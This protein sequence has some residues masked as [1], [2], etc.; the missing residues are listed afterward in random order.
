[1]TSFLYNL[2]GFLLCPSPP[3][4]LSSRCSPRPL[5]A[6]LTSSS[7]TSSFRRALSSTRANYS[8]SPVVPPGEQVQ[9]HNG[10]WYNA[11]GSPQNQQLEKSLQLDPYDF[12]AVQD[13]QEDDLLEKQEVSKMSVYGPLFQ[14]MRTLFA[15]SGVE[16]W[17]QPFFPFHAHVC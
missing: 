9:S 6:T 2:F 17:L 16:A 15:C 3:G 12:S 4:D 11:P 7:S 1:M 10:Q 8:I 14:N 13:P 5:R